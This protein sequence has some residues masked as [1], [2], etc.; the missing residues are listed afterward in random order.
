M[1][2]NVVSRFILADS[3]GVVP[4]VVLPGCSLGMGLDVC[5]A[6]DGFVGSAMQGPPQK[7]MNSDCF[8]LPASP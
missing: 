4:L 3:P 7:P 8:T 1:E 6:D 2:K 5:I